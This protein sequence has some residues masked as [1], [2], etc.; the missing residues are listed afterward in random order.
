M[1]RPSEP[2]PE[3]LT[4]KQV[5]D[6]LKVDPETLE[7]WRG[8]RQGPTWIK[9]GNGRRSP[10]RYRMADIQAFLLQNEVS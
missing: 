7:R 6:M 3:L 5:A 4:P 9:L 2:A 8:K 1:T 10:V